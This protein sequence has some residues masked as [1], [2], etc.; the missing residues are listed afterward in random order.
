MGRIGPRSKEASREVMFGP[1]AI[2]RLRS[3][4]K[5]EGR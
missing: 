2:Q 5:T 4:S 3:E 1:F